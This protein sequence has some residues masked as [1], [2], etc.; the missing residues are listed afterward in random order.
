MIHNIGDLLLDY[1]L[2]LP[3]G[4]EIDVTKAKH[5]DFE[6]QYIFGL[7]VDIQPISQENFTLLK[8]RDK[9][10]DNK[11]YTILW[12]DYD[13]EVPK[14]SFDQIVEFKN[15]LRQVEKEIEN[16]SDKKQTNSKTKTK[17]SKSKNEHV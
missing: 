17:R 14:Y 9:Y 15:N 5:S 1:S 2:V 3:R 6:Q 8:D 7:I 16:E 4:V 12:A 11:F 13:M 10:I